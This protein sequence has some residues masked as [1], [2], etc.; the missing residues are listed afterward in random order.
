MTEA[1]TR[2]MMDANP[3]Q[4]EPCPPQPTPCVME[5]PDILQWLHDAGIIVGEIG[6]EYE[7]VTRVCI[8]MKV[9]EIVRVHVERLADAAHFGPTKPPDLSGCEPVISE[10]RQALPYTP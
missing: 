2:D 8:D 5:R 6:E 10:M 1:Q 4:P 7:Q 3:P 9:G